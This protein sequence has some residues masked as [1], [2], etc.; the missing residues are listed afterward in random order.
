MTK[1]SGSIY[2]RNMMLFSISND[3]DFGWIRKVAQNASI[4]SGV[5]LKQSHKNDQS[6]LS[7]IYNTQ[8]SRGSDEIKFDEPIVRNILR[9]DNGSL[10]TR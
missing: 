5:F 2:D 9:I 8:V 4:R 7:E 1:V 6:F 10:F 3:N